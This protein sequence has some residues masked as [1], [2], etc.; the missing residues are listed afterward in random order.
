[1]MF[2][3]ENENKQEVLSGSMH[4]QFEVFLIKQ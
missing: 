3:E 2:V 1:M 4:D